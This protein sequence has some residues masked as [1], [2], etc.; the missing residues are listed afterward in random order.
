MLFVLQA[1]MRWRLLQLDGVQLRERATGLL[2]PPE[3]EPEETLFG[4]ET[5]VSCTVR[6][7]DTSECVLLAVWDRWLTVLS[8]ESD[9]T[10]VHMPLVQAPGLPTSA[11]LPP[12]VLRL[13][14]WDG[15]EHTVCD[16][17]ADPMGNPA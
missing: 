13:A 6:R 4:R 11:G 2:D 7:S 9:M 3:H 15:D 10:V 16:S 5:V 1:G 12:R 17:A 8:L 14:T